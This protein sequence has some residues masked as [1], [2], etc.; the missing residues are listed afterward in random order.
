MI[1]IT[2]IS[3]ETSRKNSAGGIGFELYYKIIVIEVVRTDGTG[4]KTNRGVPWCLSG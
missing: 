3:K 4:I 1:I 2:E